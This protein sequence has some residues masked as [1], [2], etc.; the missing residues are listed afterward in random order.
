MSPRLRLSGF[1]KCPIC[2]KMLKSSAEGE[3]FWL[4]ACN[5]FY[6]VTCI[7]EYIMEKANA[8]Q[9]PITCAN[10][11]CGANIEVRKVEKLLS[12]HEFTRIKKLYMKWDRKSLSNIVNCPNPNCSFFFE[13]EPN[14]KKYD[15]VKC[16]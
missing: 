11:K 9:F 12:R 2:S 3:V 10:E 7:K 1:E 14:M 16:N 8:T 6:H 4:D 15:C 13:K 5:D